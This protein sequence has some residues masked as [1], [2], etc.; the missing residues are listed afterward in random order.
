MVY[1]KVPIVATLITFGISSLLGLLLTGVITFRRSLFSGN[2][3]HE[4]KLALALFSKL[5]NKQHNI[6]KK[7]KFFVFYGI[8][9]A[10]NF[11]NIIL[12]YHLLLFCYLTYLLLFNLYICTYMCI[13]IYVYFILA[14]LTVNVMPFKILST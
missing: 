12:N 7:K 4:T 1:R 10:F 8:K 13:Y 5:K 14:F 6:K 2:K 3:N 9:M 11:I